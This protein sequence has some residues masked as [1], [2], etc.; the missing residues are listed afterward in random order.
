MRNM[1]NMMQK[2]S[3]LQGKMQDLQ[4]ELS[5]MQFEANAA[6]GQVRAVVN[7]KKHIISIDIDPALMVPSEADLV[8]DLVKLAIQNA[9]EMAEAEQARRVAELTD[10]LPL[11]PG[12]SLPF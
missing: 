6:G 8:A 12:M 10:G 2:I 1:A 4:T 7:G 9:M 11:P 3:G 5:D